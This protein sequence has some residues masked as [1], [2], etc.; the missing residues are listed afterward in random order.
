MD[1]L[2]KDYDEAVVIEATVVNSTKWRTGIE[3]YSSLEASSAVDNTED[4]N[5]HD[6]VDLRDG[7]DTYDP[8]QHE[9]D[10]TD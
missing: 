1:I 6:I 2:D 7:G 10:L 3:T 5:Y 4:I 9:T 8:G